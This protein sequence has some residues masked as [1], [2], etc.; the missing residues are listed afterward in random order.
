MDDKKSGWRQFQKSNFNS[1]KI[2]KRARKAE[3]ATVR[4]ARKFLV[5]RVDNMREVQR[6]IV[7]W[8]IVVGCLIVTVGLQLIWFQKSYTSITPDEG[9]TYAE[10]T[11]GPIN[12]LDPLY[13]STPVE[14]AASK[15]L[16]SSLYDYDATGHLRNDLATSVRANDKGDTYTVKLAPNVKWH[17]GVVLT[18]EDIVFTV[19]LIKNPDTRSVLRTTW[20]DVSVK[21]VDDS[22]VVFTLPSAY[23]AFPHAL[24]FA[25]LPAHILKDIAPSAVREN[26]FSLAPVGTGPF[27]FRFLQ[28]VNAKPLHKI[29]YLKGYENY[30]K[31]SPKLNRFELHAFESNEAIASA[32]RSG[33]VNAAV[34][35]AD[36]GTFIKSDK[37]DVST[38]PLNGGVYALF[39]IEQPI[40]KDLE[41]RRALQLGTNTVSVRKAF[42][43]VPPALDLPF[44]NGQIGD[45]NVPHAQL[46]DTKKA[47]ELLDKAGWIKQGSIRKKGEQK[48]TLNVVTTKNPDYEKTLEQ[49][50]G[51]WRQLGIDVQTNV[52]DTKDP[53]QNFVQNILQPRSYD[54]LIYE[55]SIGADPDVYAYWHSSQTGKNGLNFSNY[56]GGVADDTLSSAR[57]R[58]EPGLRELK[59]KTFAQQWLD[60]APAIGLYQSTMSYVHTKKV[61][62]L[63][64]DAKFIA[65]QDRY[66]NILYW[67][68]GQKS[69][70]NTP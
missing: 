1:K 9:G 53:A 66:E 42:E 61:F 14:A 34:D 57:S 22:T 32:L 12:T 29:A 37:F 67:S 48:L 44:I 6:R 64:K 18:A 21:A 47:A 62:S 17:D 50:A 4:H 41:V 65:P 10:A 69:V 25:V 49:L 15:L 52:V 3:G 8:L 2:A 13:A 63:G 51:Q 33:E 5:R 20:Q 30:H 28:T 11:L 54:V 39:N 36:I 68:A 26:T 19:N 56:K 35:S 38:H 27:E 58:S 46:Y 16:F 40:L 60:D 31:G 23:A 24:T 70:Y 45:S 59:Y 55:L 43:L 7:M